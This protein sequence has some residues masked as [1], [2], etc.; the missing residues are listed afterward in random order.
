MSH[1]KVDPWKGNKEVKLKVIITWM[2]VYLKV[3]PSVSVNAIFRMAKNF[4][5]SCPLKPI[6]IFE[7]PVIGDTK[8]S[9]KKV[10]VSGNPTDLTKKGPT[11]IFFFLQQKRH[12]SHLSKETMYC[13]RS[14]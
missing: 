7:K 13:R 8:T 2:H 3:F 6:H 14:V 5:A 9:W 4:C 12:F 11:L 10:C 1:L